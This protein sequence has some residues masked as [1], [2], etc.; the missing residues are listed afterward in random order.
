MLICEQPNVDRRNEP[1]GTIFWPR[2][3]DQ[4]LV[5]WTFAFQRY[6]KAFGKRVLMIGPSSAGQPALSDGWWSNFTEYLS[7]HR[8]VIPDLWSYHQLNGRQSPNC[9]NDPVD[10][11]Q[12][13]S[14]I[15]YKHGLPDNL[16][17]Q[18]NEYAY[19]DEQT[20]AY[21]AWFI[22]RFER[23]DEIA[24]RANWGSGR[25][26][27]DDL[28]KLVLPVNDGLGGYSALGDW[29]VLNYYTKQAKGMVVSTESTASKCYD[30][31]ATVD[32]QART[33]HI[34]AGTRG[35]EGSYPITVNGL[36]KLI[37]RARSPAV[38]AVI[39]EIPF[40]NGMTVFAPTLISKEKVAVANDGSVSINLNMVTDSAYTVDLLY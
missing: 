22:S 12:G 7:H 18:V 14:Q 1:D 11:R 15:L 36:K 29:H 5:Q 21:T 2:T 4:Y 37:P 17:V 28:A 25:G 10:S 31:Y 40:N 30:S 16:P 8:T 3:Q 24:L 39:K 26:L 32:M 20:P 34:L 13:L 6:R 33:V 9:G 38:T 35:Q 23:A 19:K 27:H